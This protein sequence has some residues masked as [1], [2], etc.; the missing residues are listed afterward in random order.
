MITGRTPFPYHRRPTN[1]V[2]P[3]GMN[4]LSDLVVRPGM[5]KRLWPLCLYRGQKRKTNNDG[6]VNVAAI[7][8]MIADNPDDFFSAEETKRRL[9]ETMRR[10]VGKPH[11]MNMKT[12]QNLQPP[13]LSDDE[14]KARGYPCEC[15]FE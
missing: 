8:K 12:G 3:V 9:A 1:R 13:L 14:L 15:G 10:V 2:V 5:R 6:P 11:T 7:E 4:Y